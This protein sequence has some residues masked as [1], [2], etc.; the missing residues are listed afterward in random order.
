M[1]KCPDGPALGGT[2]RWERVNPRGGLGPWPRRLLLLPEALNPW[3]APA[4]GARPAQPLQDEF[5]CRAPL[6]VKP[7]T[8]GVNAEER[9]MTSGSFFAGGGG[10]GV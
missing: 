5:P 2:G 1:R 10:G 9:Q 4:A 6:P 8:P 7:A 3:V